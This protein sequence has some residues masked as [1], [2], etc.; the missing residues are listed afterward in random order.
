MVISDSVMLYVG[1]QGGLWEGS[2]ECVKEQKQ[3]KNTTHVFSTAGTM[4][5][6]VFVS[7]RCR[8]GALSDGALVLVDSSIVVISIRCSFDR[9]RSVAVFMVD[10]AQRVGSVRDVRDIMISDTDMNIHR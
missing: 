4:R 6:R 10:C 9:F 2:M 7:C 8:L 1:G 3:H 5:S